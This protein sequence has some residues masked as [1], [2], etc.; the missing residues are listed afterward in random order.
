VFNPDIEQ[1]GII[2]S[3]AHAVEDAAKSYN[4]DIVD[5]IEKS[6]LTDIFAN[7]TEDFTVF[8]Q[9]PRAIAG[10]ILDELKKK[11]I[12]VAPIKDPKFAPC[13]ATTGFWMGYVV[14]QWVFQEGITGKELF[15]YDFEEVYWAY[16]V[17]HTQSVNY[18]IDFIKKE[19]SLE[20][21]KSEM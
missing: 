5:F 15:T 3:Y 20:K 1:R 11:H 14:M 10:K 21:Q 2:K 18:A 7:Y 16:D 12:S 13:D 4:C 19:Y 8:G 6:F 9:S 17:L